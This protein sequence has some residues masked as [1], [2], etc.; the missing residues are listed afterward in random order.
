MPADSSGTA[1]NVTTE[2]RDTST[3]RNVPQQAG[4]QPEYGRA[5]DRGYDEQMATPGL[6][7]GG[8]MMS[9]AANYS[10]A[11]VLL[12][13]LCL[14]AAGIALLVWPHATLTIV[15]LIIGA[16]VVVSGITRLYEG[17]TSKDRSGGMR[18]AYV[19]IGFLAVLAGLYLLR[20]HALSIFL[21]AFV[22]GVYFIAHGISD[23]GVAS[24]A[25]VPG[26]GLRLVLGIFSIGAGIVMVVWPGLTLVLLLTI[27]GAWLIFYGLVLSGLA[28]GLRKIAKSA[29][30]AGPSMSAGNERLAASGTR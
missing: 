12:G 10:W 3:Q 19:V 18:T 8:A 20:H 13:G 22:T 17:F 5:Q 6:G 24:S 2:A 14:I 26:R 25:D 30:S 21:I 16:A 15:A 27:V 23:I 7:G 28:F 4:R 11:T 29:T 9:K 1:G